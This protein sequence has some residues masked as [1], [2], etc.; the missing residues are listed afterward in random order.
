MFALFR[1]WPFCA[2]IVLLGLLPGQGCASGPSS[3]YAYP[4]AGSVARRA[5][6]GRAGAKS[7]SARPVLLASD[8]PFIPSDAER[9]LEINVNRFLNA[10][11]QVD[12]LS[13]FGIGVVTA[14]LV[15]YNLDTR[16]PLFIVAFAAACLLGSVYGYLNGS[17]TIVIA[18]LICGILAPLKF[19][20]QIKTKNQGLSRVEH[21]AVAWVVRSVAILAVSAGVFALVVDSPLSTGMR[22]VVGHSVAEAIPLLL[23]GIA[24]LAWLVTERAPAVALIKQILIAA[25]FLL[26]GVSLLMPPGQWSRFVGAVV[27]AIYVFDLVWLI[28]GNLQRTLRIHTARQTLDCGSPDC[29]A[30]GVCG[31]D[32]SANGDSEQGGKR[33]WL[34][35]GVGIYAESGRS[36]QHT[37]GASAPSKPR[38]VQPAESRQ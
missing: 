15:F 26:W 21:L 28:E 7:A 25:A 1:K 8:A 14:L 30:S 3:A 4:E 17:R 33:H 19:W 12:G 31:C 37:N 36:G 6:I 11:F 16:S 22:R 10:I 20:H 27:I 35:D 23:V 5:G 29:Q 24:Y 13:W 9:K 2:I 32:R 18:G 34:G 38:R